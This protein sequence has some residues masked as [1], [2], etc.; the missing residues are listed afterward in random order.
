MTSRIALTGS[1]F[2]LFG[3]HTYKWRYCFLLSYRLRKD[4]PQMGL[5]LK[6]YTQF[7]EK[8]VMVHCRPYF[9]IEGHSLLNG[10]E[11]EKE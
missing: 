2:G 11:K 6:S 10:R 5:Q 3:V 9:Y 1:H 4:V 8:F 7:W